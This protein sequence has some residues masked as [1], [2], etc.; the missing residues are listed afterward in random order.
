MS[1]VVDTLNK[2][3]YQTLMTQT[4][5][6]YEELHAKPIDEGDLDDYAKL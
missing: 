3:K 1:S 6:N 4:L 2:A 5:N